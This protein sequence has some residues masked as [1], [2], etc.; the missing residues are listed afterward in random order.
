MMRHSCWF[1]TNNVLVAVNEMREKGLSSGCTTG[2]DV[3]GS[4]SCR[5]ES[6]HLSQAPIAGFTARSW[7]L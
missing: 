4:L 5:K 1:G 3:N 6:Q 2:E 7:S